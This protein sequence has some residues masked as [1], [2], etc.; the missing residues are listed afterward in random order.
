MVVVIFIT[1]TAFES[2]F[3]CYVLLK[4]MYVCFLVLFGLLAIIPIK[5]KANKV[6]AIFTKLIVLVFSLGGLTLFFLFGEYNYF[7]D[8]PDY[9]NKNYKVI[10]GPAKIT[11]Y[12]VRFTTNQ[13]ITIH[14]INFDNKQILLNEDVYNGKV[15]KVEYLPHSKY[16]IEIWY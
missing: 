6:K 14:G 4:F 15:L 10:D 13:T 3:W 16:V 1:L 12:K 11:T 8:I 7:L 9:F 5:L 2:I